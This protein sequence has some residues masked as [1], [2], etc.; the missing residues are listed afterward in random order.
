[1]HDVVSDILANPSVPRRH[2]RAE[3]LLAA[4]RFRDDSSY[5]MPVAAWRTMARHMGVENMGGRSVG[6]LQTLPTPTVTYGAV[7]QHDDRT[8][9][10]TGFGYGEATGGAHTGHDAPTGPPSPR[11][12]PAPDAPRPGA[13]SPDPHAGHGAPPAADTTPVAPAPR[14][15]PTK[16]RRRPVPRPAPAP[17]PRRDPHA[18]HTP[19]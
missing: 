13:P 9:A 15:A 17:R 8:G 11:T 2:K 10:M 6:F 12:S 18:G 3:I 14:A 5:V 7:M 19:P 16:A 4:R 1:M